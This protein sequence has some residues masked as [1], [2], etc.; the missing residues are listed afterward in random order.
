MTSAMDFDIDPF[1]ETV[2]LEPSPS[3]GHGSPPPDPSS[4]TEAGPSN[5]SPTRRGSLQ[6]SS[7]SPTTHL[8]HAYQVENRHHT[9]SPSSSINTPKS[10]IHS[11]AAVTT[12]GR[13]GRPTL[14]DLKDVEEIRVSLWLGVNT[15]DFIF[16]LTRLPYLFIS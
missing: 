6:T 2:V 13:G 4:P 14:R 16:D 3:I 11:I 10:P 7:A 12:P 9:V 5:S 15:V 1:K 8:V